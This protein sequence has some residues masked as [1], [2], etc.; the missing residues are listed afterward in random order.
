MPKWPLLPKGIGAHNYKWIQQGVW[1]YLS[2][3]KQLLCLVI[4]T[5]GLNELFI[6]FDDTYV[7]RASKKAPD[8]KY[9][10][11][12]GNKPNRP[13]YIW[14]QC[15]LTMAVAL[16][17]GCAV[18]IVSRLL[19]TTSNT[20]KL[21]AAKVILR[22]MK[23]VL[24]SIQTTMLVD[25]WFMRK[26]LI[27]PALELGLKVIGQVRIDTALFE[28]PESLKNQGR[29]RPRIYGDKI[30]KDRI[31]TL[32]V[33]RIRMFIYNKNQWVHYRHVIAKARFLRGRVV[34]AVLCQFENEDGSLSRPRLILCTDTKHQPE[35]IL[36]LY[37][38][39]RT[40]EPMFNQLK[41]HW[42]MDTLWQQSRQ[43]VSRWLQIVSIS[44]AIPQML[45]HLGEDQVKSLMI[46]TPWRSKH[47]VTAGRIRLGL[48]RILGHFAVRSWWNPKSRI[49]GPPDYSTIASEIQK[50]PEAS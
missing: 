47:P 33:K 36:K 25:S 26:T 2:L 21:L 4:E 20:G 43:V 8:V 45:V 48:R 10:H 46:H 31:M 1:S 30:T 14:G 37:A 7:A 3:A 15:W 5:F 39:R 41:N 27:L 13:K 23:S 18:P 50:L 38:K 32:P 34:K 9:H 6:I 35:T 22:A 49:F 16:G 17:N 44:Y 12:H 19:S 28:I 11:Q 40:I 42:G 29:G 24:T